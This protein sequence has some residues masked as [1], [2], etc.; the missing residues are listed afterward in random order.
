MIYDTKTKIPTII[1][2]NLTK[3]SSNF[4]HGFVIDLDNDM[5]EVY[6]GKNLI[7]LKT[8]EW[9]YHNGYFEKIHRLVW[10]KY[11]PI[12]L[13]AKY[14][15]KN[16]TDLYKSYYNEDLLVQFYPDSEPIISEFDPESWDENDI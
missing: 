14:K 7:P 15:F 10:K 2:T 12:R 4:G 9:F 3:Y 11:Y 6:D 13:V 5:L 16:L 8:T 1:N